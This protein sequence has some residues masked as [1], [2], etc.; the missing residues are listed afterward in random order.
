VKAYTYMILEDANGVLTREL[1]DVVS[2]DDTFRA[3]DYCN[4]QNTVSARLNDAACFRV[5]ELE[6]REDIT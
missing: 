4:Q 1:E 6:E 3:V 5:T 2:F